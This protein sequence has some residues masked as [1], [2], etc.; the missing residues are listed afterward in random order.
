M[1]KLIFHR[2]SVKY[3]NLLSYVVGGA[4][5]YEYRKSQ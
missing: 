2:L 5:D 4:F 3:N 1:S